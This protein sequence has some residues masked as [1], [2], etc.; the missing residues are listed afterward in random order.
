MDPDPSRRRAR[1]LL[2]MHRLPFHPRP[3]LGFRA[4]PAVR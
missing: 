3:A 1:H 2:A 4:H